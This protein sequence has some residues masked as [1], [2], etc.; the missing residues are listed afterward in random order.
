M[1][2]PFETGFDSLLQILRSLD[3]ATYHQRAAFRVSSLDVSLDA[4]N[5]MT[6]NTTE[7]IFAEIEAGT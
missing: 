4:A 2:T 7:S 3:N 1:N 5:D 6:W